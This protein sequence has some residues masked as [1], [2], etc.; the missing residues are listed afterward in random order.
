MQHIQYL[1]QLETCISGGK[2]GDDHIG[3]GIGC[4]E[5]LGVLILNLDHVVT[6]QVGVEHVDFIRGEAIILHLRV[7]NLFGFGHVGSLCKF[8]SK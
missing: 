5:I 1:V 6:H 2:R 7:S 3:F 4:D 8:T